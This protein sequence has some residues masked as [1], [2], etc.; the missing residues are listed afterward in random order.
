MNV[1]CPKCHMENAYHN[2]IDMECPDC[3][4][5]WSINESSNHEIESDSMFD[6]FAQY[7]SPFFS[8]EHGFL[9]D[10]K[11]EHEGGTEDMSIISLAF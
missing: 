9:Y 11:V 2:G 5:K 4:N 8:L 6:D 3:D 1:T 10:C 7:D